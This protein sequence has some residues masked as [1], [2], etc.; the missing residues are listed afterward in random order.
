MTSAR[1]LRFRIET[2]RFQ[3]RRAVSALSLFY[4]MRKILKDACGAYLYA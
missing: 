2:W 4:A 1:D 3:L